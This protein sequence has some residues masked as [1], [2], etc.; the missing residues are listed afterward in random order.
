MGANEESLIGKAALRGPSEHAPWAQQQEE[1]VVLLR[2][3]VALS[4]RTW[5]WLS[6]KPVQEI[7]CSSHLLPPFVQIQAAA[8]GP[9]SSVI[10]HVLEGS[11]RATELGGEGWEWMW[12][13]PLVRLLREGRRR[14]LVRVSLVL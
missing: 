7:D 2:G 3:A 4:R 13:V 11:I 1:A 10:L 5:C 6:R 8:G 9:Q 12:K 14:G